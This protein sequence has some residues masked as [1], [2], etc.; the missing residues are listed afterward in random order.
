MNIEEKTAQYQIASI[1]D[2]LTRSKSSAFSFLSC[3]LVVVVF[4]KLYL[5]HPQLS[6]LNIVLFALYGILGV[7]YRYIGIQYI[8]THPRKLFY[9]F[10][11]L[12]AI[13]SF[14]WGML[15]AYV[16]YY[17]DY[18]VIRTP[19]LMMTI[20]IASLGI[21]NTP[22]S[23]SGGYVY[24]SFLFFPTIVIA[25]N[26]G[27]DESLL[28]ALF[29]TLIM[30]ALFKAIRITTSRYYT[31]LESQISLENKA[32]FLHDISIK[33][34]LTGLYNRLHL[35]KRFH[36][37]WVHAVKSRSEIA[38]LMIDIDFFK[39]INDNHGHLAG[40]KCLIEVANEIKQ[41]AR[42]QGDIAARYGGEEFTLLLPQISKDYAVR[43]A[44]DLIVAIRQKHIE[45]DTQN[46]PITISIGLA[47]ST[48]SEKSDHLDLLRSA[49]EALYSAKRSGRDRF[50]IA[51]THR[52]PS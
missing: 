17:I 35:E 34:P 44:E 51:N 1:Q 36:K 15:S 23:V 25:I 12:V 24:L 27:T 41:F 43:V 11:L 47:L 20:I 5:L 16:T 29:Y 26:N 18:T 48:P 42:R 4:G 22:F 3:W 32:D 14:H 7:T 31:T 28:V 10:F 13:L 9:L 52:T 45:Y 40:D 38:V 6:Y 50:S 39:L 19:M 37:E 49:D 33:D 21:I 30:L 46:I 8:E 2:L